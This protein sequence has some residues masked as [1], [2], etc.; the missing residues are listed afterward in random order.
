M[1][2]ITPLDFAGDNVR[3]LVRDGEPWWVA[4]DVVRSLGVANAR[5]ALTRL[6]EYEKG[7]GI[8]DTRGGPQS[9]AIINES[10][11]YS[12]LLTSRKPVAKAMKRWLTTEVLPSI[13]KHGSYP[14]P[15]LQPE[16]PAPVDNETPW[17]GAE[18]TLGQRFQEERLRWEAEK[19]FPL[20]GTVSTMTKAIVRAI[21]DDRGGIRKGQRM[22]WLLYAEFDILYVI[23]GTRTLTAT[24]RAVRDAYRS[25]DLVQRAVAAKTVLSL[26]PVSDASLSRQSDKLQ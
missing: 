15:A 21:E 4:D 11:F 19:G 9:V 8:T 2:A 24:E 10:G 26:A 25:A 13:R 14:P 23:T 6:E 7:V 20:A 3:M 17:E 1:N 16:L 18:K 5:D 12:L 22:E